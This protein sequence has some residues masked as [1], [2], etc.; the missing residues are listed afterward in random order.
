MLLVITK[1]HEAF[2]DGPSYVAT[3]EITALKHKV[4]NHSV[5]FRV[6]KRILILSRAFAKRGKV[7]SRLW[8]HIIVKLETD[9]A[10]LGWT[11]VSLGRSKKFRN[12]WEHGGLYQEKV[13]THLLSPSSDGCCHRE[14]VLARKHRSKHLS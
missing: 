13:D 2:L 4:W 8:N 9:A 14:L 10:R 5:E 1:G 6:C 12:G 11:S 7:L 3:S